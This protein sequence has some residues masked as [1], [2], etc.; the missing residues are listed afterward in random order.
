YNFYLCVL[1]IATCLITYYCSVKIFQRTKPALICTALYTLSAVRLT[2]ILTRAALG[3][4]AAQTFLPLLILGFY[5]IYSALRGGE[6]IP[7]RKY[8]PI[9][10][11]MTGILTSHTLTTEMSAMVILAVCLIFIRKTLERQRL[12]ALVRAALLSLLVN[13]STLVPMLDSMRMDMN[14]NHV[15]SQIQMTGAYLIQIFNS[16]VNNYQ[17]YQ[18]TDTA[19]GEL[20]L[21]IGFSLTLGLVF[22]V[23]YL[24]K[25]KREK[26]RDERIR[27]FASLCFGLCAAAIFLS[28]TYMFYDYLDFL[29]DSLYSILTVYQYP[30]RWLSFA[31]LFGAFG[32][33][34]IADSAELKSV[35]QGVSVTLLL[36]AALVINAGQ[37]YADQLRTSELTRW[38]NNLNDYY[39]MVGSSG[40]YLLYGTDVSQILSRE[41]DFYGD[42]LT[43]ADYACEDGE[44]LL[45][46]DNASDG[47]ALIDLPLFCYDNYIAYDTQTGESISITTGEN[48]RIRLNVPAGYTGTIRVE[49]HFRK[50]WLLAIGV[51][52]AVTVLLLLYA[53]FGEKRLSGKKTT[54]EK[55]TNG[56][57]RGETSQEE[58]T[59]NGEIP[60]KK[61]AKDQVLAKETAE[62]RAQ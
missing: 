37:I 55:I 53:G 56:E 33:A 52:A 34:A 5:E 57:D 16:V 39:Y 12:L 31:A 30:W 61:T 19:S 38:S 6:K 24:V 11:G 41:P 23:V 10:V 40:E 1:S 51:S 22:Y 43:V 48:N 54:G 29:P 27:A 18:A 49:Y 25:Q 21:S 62:G 47:T 4:V 35:F 2:N 26:D 14:I 46:V 60:A 50:L 58:K 3:E 7:L 42:G 17:E 28:T 8:W 20:S 32:T 9:I 36:C 45:W 44:A 15:V 13:L 59:A